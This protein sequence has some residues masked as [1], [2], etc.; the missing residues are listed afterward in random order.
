MDKISLVRPNKKM[1][2]EAIEFKNE[3][4][5]NGEY[6]I[7][8][9]ELWDK[10]DNYDIWLENVIKNISKETVDPNWVVTDTFFAVRENDE[11]IIGIIDFRH[12]LNDF[13]K[14]F[15]HC[16]YS[17]RPSER[18]KG[19]ATEMLKK[20]IKIAQDM[21]LKEVQLSCETE[22]IPSVKT[23]IKNGGKYKRSFKYHDNMADVYIVNL[24]SGLN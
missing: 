2:F 7:N 11:K 12:E 10:T 5:R 9:S 20:V 4:F 21:G 14:D 8:G 19:Y 1:E 24:D 15:G 6:E 13:L 3:F 23:I 16:G 18:K 22:N 17:V